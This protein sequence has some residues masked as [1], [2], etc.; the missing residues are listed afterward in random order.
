MGVIL[1]ASDSLEWL[2]RIAGRKPAELAA[3]VKVDGPSTVTFLPYL[4]GERT[5]WNDAGARGA[6]VGL[7]QTDGLADMTQA[8]LEGVAYAFADCQRVL[9]DAGTDFAAALA[10][11][12]GARSETWLRIIASVLDRPLEIAADSDVGR[13][14]RRGAARDLRGG[15]GRPGSRSARRRRSCGWSSPTRRWCRAMRRATRA[16][17]RSI[18]R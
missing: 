8:V 6:F 3:A 16:I 1:S 5:P 14:A 10:V 18:R 4:S 2:S 11:G 12:G 7:A 17:A 9:K 15:G 13:G